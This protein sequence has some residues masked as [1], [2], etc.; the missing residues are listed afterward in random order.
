MARMTITEG[1]A[2]IKT[3]GA[4][5]KKKQE[6]IRSYLVRQDFIKDPLAQDGGSFEVIKRERQAI[7]DLNQRLINLRVAIIYSNMITDITIAEQKRT[8]EQWLVWRRDVAPTHREFLSAMR[9]VV[10]ATRSEAAKKGFATQSASEPAK[11]PNDV[12][13]NISESELAKDIE[14]LETALG[15]LDG[16]LS[17]KNATTFI[18]VD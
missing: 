6:Y 11:N 18:E 5:V 10:N 3:I 4:K 13:V 7:G 14:D 17:L 1:L 16:Q 9:Q 2:E 15:T 8:V 12:L